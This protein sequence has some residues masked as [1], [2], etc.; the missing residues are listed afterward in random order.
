M[1]NLRSDRER[2]YI[3]TEFEDYLIKYDILSQLTVDGTPQQNGVA[4]RRN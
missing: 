3:D 2:D 1:K 4:E